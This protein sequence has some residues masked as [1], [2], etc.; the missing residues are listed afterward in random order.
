M[1]KGSLC[2]SEGLWH[3][4]ATQTVHGKAWYVTKWDRNGLAKLGT[5]NGAIIQLHLLSPNPFVIVATSINLFILACNACG[6][7]RKFLKICH[8]QAI[9]GWL[10]QA[11][12]ENNIDSSLHN[13]AKETG[14]KANR[15]LAK[16]TAQLLLVLIRYGHCPKYTVV[17]CTL[18]Y[19]LFVQMLT[20]PQAAQ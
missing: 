10:I 19:L 9:L 5:T 20:V 14:A 18:Y 6:L 7:Q 1:R 3:P 4:L 13:N 17:T 12:D 8:F 15:F 16:K 11:V 2:I